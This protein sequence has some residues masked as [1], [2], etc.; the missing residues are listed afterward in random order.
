MFASRGFRLASL[1]AMLVM[2]LSMV[3]VDQAEARR[4]GSFGSRGTR[5][6]QTAPATPTSPN[7]TA[8]V[9]RSMTPGQTTAAPRPGAQTTQPRSMFGGFGGSL[10]SGIMLGGLFGLFLGHG[11]GGVAGLFGLLVQGALIFFVIRFVMGVLSRNS[12][13]PAAAGM[14]Y[15]GGSGPSPLG[16]LSG[17]RG[18]GPSRAPR[19]PDELGVKAADLDRFEDMLREV[20]FAFGREDYSALRQ[21]TTPE[22]MSYLSEELGENASKG[23]KNEVSEV[24]LLKGDVAESWREGSQDYATAAMHYSSIDVTRDRES[25]RIVEGDADVA[26]DTTELWTFVR[27]RGS[28]WKLSAIQ[29]A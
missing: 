26:T 25:G 3:S 2:A 9:Q 6:F 7:I 19:N 10:L 16:G 17:Q 11:F 14:N 20:Q 22:M 21:L 28:E 15:S 8:P 27:T 18:S 5:T 1:F 12:R 24:K 23:L 13:Q 4:G 29:Q